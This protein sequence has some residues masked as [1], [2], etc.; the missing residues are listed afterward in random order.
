MITPQDIAIN[1]AVM[2]EKYKCKVNKAKA[3][4]A[5][6]I[7]FMTELASEGFS[8]LQI[9]NCRATIAPIWHNAITLSCHIQ[10]SY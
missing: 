1:A 6:N 3:I 5:G 4:I 9:I 2:V 7:V 10:I 8:L